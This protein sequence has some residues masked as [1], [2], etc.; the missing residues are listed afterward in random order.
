MDGHVTKLRHRIGHG[1]A[2]HVQQGIAK[3][4]RDGPFNRNSVS[5]SIREDRL[6]AALKSLKV[7]PPNQWRIH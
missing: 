4:P 7:L 1:G 3:G 5:L 6:K 2:P